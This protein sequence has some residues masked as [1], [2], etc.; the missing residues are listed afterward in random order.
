MACRKTIGL[1]QEQSKIKVCN[2]KNLL[3]F[4]TRIVFLFAREQN[5]TY[6]ILGR[7]LLKMRIFRFCTFLFIPYYLISLLADSA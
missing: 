2:L 7:F 6:G 5:L 1:K 4:M 3:L